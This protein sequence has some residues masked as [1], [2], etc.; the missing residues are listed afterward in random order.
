[1]VEICL[2]SYLLGGKFGALLASI[3][4]PLFSALYCVLF[5]Y[6]V[7]AGLCLL[8]YCNLNTLRTKFILSVSLFMG[9]SIPQYFR[10]YE[11]FFGFGP[12]HTH[13]VVFNVMVNVIFSSPA[14]EAQVRKDRG[15]HWWEK[16]KSNKN[17]TRSEEFY[18][19]PYGLS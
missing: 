18:A 6:S 8:Q 2:K 9:L 11:M 19:L 4:L 7:G 1:M 15:W 3:P 5:A 16:F 17:D 13:S 14:T 10:I 12:V